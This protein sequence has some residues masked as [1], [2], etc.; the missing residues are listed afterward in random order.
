MKIGKMSGAHYLVLGEIR[1]VAGAAGAAETYTATMRV[2]KT[3][4]GIIIG[5]GSASGAF[6]KV[7]DSLGEQAVRWL[8]IYL[9]MDNPESPY[10]VLLKL[11]KGTNPT[12]KL[13]DKL[14][15]TFKVLAHKPT[16]PRRVYIQIYSINAQG[17]MIMIYPNKFSRTEVI[18]VDKEYRFPEDSDDFEW[19]LVPPVGTESI[20]AIVTTKPVDLFDMKK[21]YLNDE[22]PQVKA[23]G[24]SEVTYR[25]INTKLKKEKIG[26]YKAEKITYEL[27]EK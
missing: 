14:A 9:V 1:K 3:E 8:S 15:L 11:D 21:S 2:V 7:A 16:A 26:D 5:A 23:S 19:E 10:S 17:A 12:Y 24:H 20:Q 6:N 22:F 13:G 4:T 18:D 25:G 27:V